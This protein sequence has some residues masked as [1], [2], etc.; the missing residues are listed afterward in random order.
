MKL[1][2]WERCL[3]KKARLRR[4]A[5]EVR[6]YYASLPPE[7]VSIGEREALAFLESRGIDILPYAFQDEYGPDCPTLEW[8]PAAG[9]Y[10]ARW[11]GRRLYYRATRDP[12][13][14][15]GYLRGLLIEQDPRSPHR[16]ES[17]DFAVN[18]GDTVLDVG[19]AEGN[20][21]LSAVERAGRVVLFEPS[22]EWERPLEATFAPWKEKVRVLPHRVSDRNEGGAV[23]LDAMFPGDERVD[24][25][26]I[27]VEGHEERVLRGAMALIER[28][29]TLRIAVCTYHRQDDADRLASWLGAL[30]FQI[31]FA[32]GFLLYYHGRDN[33]LRPP[34]L[35]RAVLRATRGRVRTEEAT[36]K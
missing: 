16:Y 23:T 27:D 29:A 7:R 10:F 1:S 17:D 12:E 26:K 33:E 18:A 25:I 31:R 35:R 20:F 36:P 32:P 24:F 34:Y 22:S 8:D 5:R 21:G 9:L 30:G 13:K 15:R 2:L 6:E 28:S 11:E 4:L 3:G 19:A 14:A